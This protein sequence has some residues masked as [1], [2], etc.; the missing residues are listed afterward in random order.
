MTGKICGRLLIISRADNNKSGDAYWNCICKCGKH[1][2]VKGSCLRSGHTKSC[3]CLQREFASRLNS[4]SPFDKCKGL[5]MMDKVKS[6][7][8]AMKQRCYNKNNAEYSY[9]GGKGIHI[10][11]EWILEPYK[12]YFWSISNGFKP[13]LTIDR[14]DNEKGYSPA[15]CRFATRADQNR[16]TT[17]VHLI[18]DEQSNKMFTASQVATIIGVSRSTASKWFVNENLRT[19]KQFKERAYKMRCKK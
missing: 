18:T 6:I 2:V 19:L 12:F 17:R 11:D 4:D 13:G 3:G 14:I 8:I 1:M 10:C 7:F 9:Y 15:N 5:P 16:N